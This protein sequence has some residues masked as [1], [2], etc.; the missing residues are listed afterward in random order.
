VLTRDIYRDFYKDSGPTIGDRLFVASK[1]LCFVFA[2]AAL[3]LGALDVMGVHSILGAT[4]ALHDAPGKLAGLGETLRNGISSISFKAPSMES[5]RV[6]IPQQSVI[7]FSTKK[8]PTV[9]DDLVAVR[10]QD[11]VQLAMTSAHP[12]FTAASAQSASLSAVKST[13]PGTAKA[14]VLG[15]MKSEA[16]AAMKVEASVK[17][18]SLPLP[19]DPVSA[20]T[21]PA[22]LSLAKETTASVSTPDLTGTITLPTKNV[23]MPPAAPPVSPAD[24]LGLKGAEYTKAERCLANAIYFEARSEPVR[25]QMAVAQVILNRAFSGV[26]PDDVCSVVYQN[27]HRRLACQFTFACDGKSKAILDRGSWARSMRIARQTLDGQIYLPEVGKSTHYHAT[28]VSPTWARTMHRLVRHGVHNF[29]RPYAWGRGDE[30]PIWGTA[31]LAAEIRAK[32][33]AHVVTR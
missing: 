20:I 14:D 8:E 10:A 9:I 5:I 32:T 27:A 33:A 31:A 13:V 25:G 1:R 11:A 23:P 16:P 28:Y 21:L 26:Y 24:R 18:A 22:S 15:T 19:S 3:S 7:R 12:T 17:L 4:A 29:Y 6:A 2:G 30:K